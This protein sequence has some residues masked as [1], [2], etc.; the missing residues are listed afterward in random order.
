[1]NSMPAAKLEAKV[2]S[3]TKGK[4][5]AQWTIQISNISDKLAFFVRPQL[6]KGD[7]EVMPS[8]WTANYF[9]LAPHER[10]TVS[11]SAPVAKLGNTTPTVLLEG[12][13]AEKQTISLS[14]NAK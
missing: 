14:V 10:I 1:L 6:M 11:V 12:W 7:E 9:T 8:Y 2:L 4:S 13:N 3:V 5:E